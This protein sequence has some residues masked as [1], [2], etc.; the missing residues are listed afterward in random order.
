MAFKQ[1]KIGKNQLRPIETPLVGF[2]KN[3]IYPLRAISLQITADTLRPTVKWR[4]QIG[5]YSNRLRSN[6]KEA[7]SIW[8]EELLSGAQQKKLLSS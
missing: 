7:K 5:P 6:L 8:V 1:M 4:S 2:A 3:S